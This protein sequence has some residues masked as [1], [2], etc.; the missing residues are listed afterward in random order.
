[1]LISNASINNRKPVY[2]LL[3]ICVLFG[4][5]SYGVLPRESA[6]DIEIPY[7]FI[8]SH[9][10][11][12]SP[13]DIETLITLPIERKVKGISGIEQITS[14][15]SEGVSHISVEFTP[16]IEIERALQKVR[17]KVDEAKPDL[18]TDLDEPAV[19]EMNFSEF[20]ILVVN[21]YGDA[22]LAKLK[23][24]ADTIK[25]DVEGI[26]GVLS[27]TLS[28]DR[29]RVIRAE[30]DTDRLN[31]YNLTLDQIIQSIQEENVNIPAGSIDMGEGRFL[32]R[33]PG[34]FEHPQ[35]V[36][37]LPVAVKGDSIV[38]ISD[39]ATVVDDFKD[40]QSISRVDSNSCVA[41]TIQKRAG[42]NTIFIVDS[43]K[44][45]LKKF[46]F[47][48]G[49]K[50]SFSFDE[51]KN[52]RD[53]VSDL[54]NNIVSGLLLV[55]FVVFFFM[56]FK[57]SIFVGL[58]IPYSMLIS[59]TVISVM[60]ITL[61]MVVLFSLVLALGM[62][63]DNSIVIVENIY[64][65]VSMGKN[66]MTAASDAISEIGWP[67]VT[68]TLTTVAAFFP[69]IFWPGIMGEFMGYLP[70]VVIIALLA[71]LF[72]ALV[73]NPALGARFM[74]A[75]KGESAFRFE[76]SPDKGILLYYRKIVTFCVDRPKTIVG[77]AI[78]FL[79]FSIVLYGFVGK[80]VEFFPDTEPARAFVYIKMPEGTNVFRTNEFTEQIEKFMSKYKEIKHY[81]ATIG[82]GSSTGNNMT[83]AAGSLNNASIAIDFID[84]EKR[85]LDSSKILEEIRDFCGTLHGAQIEVKAEEGGPPTG[86]PINIEVSG[87]EL[88]ELERLAFAIKEVVK[89]VD[90][91]VDLRDDYVKG[92]PEFKVAIDRKKA[93][94]N[95]LSTAR[96][97]TVVKAVINGIEVGK[98]R[99]GD[100]EYDI[101][102][103]SKESQ[104]SDISKLLGLKINNIKGYPIPL[105][106][107]AKIEYE[108][109]YGAINRIDHKRVVTIS[110]N[111]LGRLPNDI[112]AE[113][114]QKL[115]NFK[116]PEGYSY[117]FTG[118]NED[119]EEAGAFLSKALLSA[120]F[121]IAMILV[122]QFNSY[123][124]PLIILSS[125][126]LS[127]AGVLWGLMITGKPFGIIM[128]GIGVISL[129]GVV[130]NNA[131]VLID[132]INQLLTKGMSKK[133]A[134]VEAGIVRFR[135][136]ILTALT[137]VLG[138]FPMAIGVSLDFK[139]MR[140]QWISESSQWWGPMASA[141]IA[142]LLFATVLTLV[143]VP[144][145]YVIFSRKKNHPSQTPLDQARQENIK[146]F[147]ADDSELE[148]QAVG[149]GVKDEKAV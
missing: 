59:F 98:Y 26:E 4:I 130:V 3:I 149:N 60:G 133:E 105:S 7:I 45:Y 134:A 104:R 94:L 2:L 78:G 62:L 125:V 15:S 47:P 23:D 48:E 100:D 131:I 96:A 88:E 137:T 112:L 18:P 12:V 108:S 110:S 76:L 31:Q 122:A 74:K 102:V 80:G 86:A 35:D 99:E 148:E 57:N 81:T 141:V 38:Y 109:G 72:V 41:L 87:D 136:V 95:G 68:S 77:A 121:L 54:E 43:V 69:M 89:N 17:D 118:E 50:Y 106:A 101:I 39:I 126:I 52:V 71:S 37:R 123:M 66:S 9:Y 144:C 124:Q 16:D 11:G 13:S 67:V 64:R 10:E 127:I 82:A 5:Y 49:V 140:I 97:A 24:L 135:P 111:A 53:M 21:L 1:M 92:K 145:L 44:E 128:T 143:V 34:E 29:E 129:A 33:V 40:V 117:E 90:G 132:Y 58:S 14:V 63:V 6:P 56:G 138:L 91:V 19:E 27:V 146:P 42:E 20:P 73:F 116:M 119:Q 113:I 22:D 142:G 30:V 120:I 8:T 114:A 139:K 147:D 51:S 61:N 70:L 46:K 107:I 84:I 115:K 79:I 93:A 85:K 25:D 65:H 28:G 36:Y 32:V 75:K 83:S 103:R 55:M